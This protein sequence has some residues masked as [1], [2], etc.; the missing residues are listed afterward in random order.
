MNFEPMPLSVGN[1]KIL[2][3]WQ[4]KL[5]AYIES[6]SKD[7]IMASISRLCAEDADFAVL[8]DKAITNGGTF[9]ELDL[10][11]WAKTNVVKAAALHRQMQELPHTLSALLL[12]IDCIK[13][14]CNRTKLAEQD[15]AEFDSEGFWHHVTMGDV[16]KY[17][18]TLLDMR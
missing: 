6:T 16:Q 15:A 9:T 10:A 5:S 2:Q 3:E 12:G 18:T 14:T 17:C 13:A 11:E 7:R 8:V 1:A 4:D